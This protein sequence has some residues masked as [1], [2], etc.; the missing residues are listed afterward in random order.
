MAAFV[1]MCVRWARLSVLD[2]YT[3]NTPYIAYSI[4]SEGTTESTALIL[5]M[6][7]VA[8]IANLSFAFLVV[9]V[10]AVVCLFVCVG[11]GSV[12][13]GVCRLMLYTT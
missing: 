13:T 5:G 3:L 1:C 9:V 6:L 8:V 7:C 11:N 12:C 2:T 4:V 10:V